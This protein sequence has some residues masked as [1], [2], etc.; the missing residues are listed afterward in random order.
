[1]QRAFRCTPP[2]HMLAQPGKPGCEVLPEVNRLTR[3]QSERQLDIPI[4]KKRDDRFLI[5]ERQRPFLPALAIGVD[6]IGGHHV[7]EAAA[8]TQS[9]DDLLV[10]ID[11]SLQVAGSKPDRNG[12]WAGGQLVTELER[13]LFA[14]H[15]RVADEIERLRHRSR[16]V[17][18]IANLR[19]S[20]MLAEVAL[21]LRDLPVKLIDFV[22]DAL[23]VRFI[24]STGEIVPGIL[25][26]LLQRLQRPFRRRAPAHMLAQPGKPGVETVDKI[27]VLPWLQP[28]RQLSILV[29]E[30][31]DD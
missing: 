27:D 5:L 28:E 16:S 4:E 6:A 8:P 24:G 9:L 30:K 3:L 15:L 11:T 21:L 14:I 2:A 13:N 31:R 17:M 10:P 26:A 7:E 20:S 25:Q 29:E 23:F 12:R 19:G 18:S 22:R 1:M